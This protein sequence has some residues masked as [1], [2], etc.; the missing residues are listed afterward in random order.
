M[1]NNNEIEN[2]KKTP[3]IQSLISG[4]TYI[5][6]DANVLLNVYHYSPEFTEFAMDCINQ[7]RGTIMLPSTVRIEYGK[8][9]DCEY[10][11]MK[12]RIKK[13]GDPL[14]KSTTSSASKLQN[15]CDDLE[16]MQF[17]DI[18]ELKRSINS[19]FE[20]IKK[21]QLVATLDVN[22][23]M[24]SPDYETLYNWYELGVSRF[25]NKIPPGFKDDDKPGI[26]KYSDLV[27]WK[28][29]LR[30][31]EAKKVNILF[32]TDDVKGDWWG[33]NP[34][35]K[36]YFR[37]E[38]IEEF[39]Q[40]TGQEIYPF[41]SA[42]FYTFI[43]DTYGVERVPAVEYALN[44]TDDEYFDKIQD[45]VFESISSKLMYSGD[46]YIDL[47]RVYL[48]TEGI[49]GYEIVEYEFV[50]ATRI[51][52]DENIVTYQFEYKVTLEGTSFDYWGRDEDTREIT[53][54]P[55]VYHRFEGTI[56]VEVTRECASFIDFESDKSFKDATITDGN[57]TEVE[58][59]DLNTDYYDDI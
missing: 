28:E 51:D 13:F 3:S 9:C 47:D 22:Q 11:A 12:N 45:D 1:S 55:G 21:K 36:I 31:A 2:E 15:L 44:M 42:E 29:T 6:L 39:K 41:T 32:V 5:V 52:R 18:D 14:L 20:E 35:G 23:I 50:S 8:H 19:K 53:L 54:S 26:D 57:L 56:T 58:S 49:D 10:H 27:L 17:P 37:P 48:G 33:V 40:E 4:S 59:K 24:E 38:L 30:F 25:K 16:K 43:S 46:N 34:N 7:I